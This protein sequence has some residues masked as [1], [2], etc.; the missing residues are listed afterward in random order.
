MNALKNILRRK[1]FTL[2]IE[3]FP[4]KQEEGVKELFEQVIPSTLSVPGKLPDFYS[5]TYGAGGIGQQSKTVETVCR[6]INGFNI[7]AVMHI[8]CASGSRANVERIV[9]NA[10]K[11]GVNN[12][13]AIRGDN[14]GAQHEL[15][16]AADIVRII[17]KFEASAVVGV[18][19]FP[20]GNNSFRES[21]QANWDYLVEKIRSGADFVITQLFFENADFLR[22]REYVSR[23]LQTDFR[24][25]AGILPI[26]SIKQVERFTKM[27][28]AKIP[29]E[30]TRQLE[31]FKNDPRAVRQIGIDFAARQSLELIDANVSGIHYY[32]LN[33]SQAVKSIISRLDLPS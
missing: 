28:D 29:A 31:R 8:T 6:I 18:A 1:R 3:L 30:V 10:F 26:T 13:L 19:G 14:S 32:C 2:S 11:R 4:P 25:I 21:V 16:Y 24:I 27:T 7:D 22:F 9:M 12:F 20:E 5:V 33:K 23:K 15:K 17:K